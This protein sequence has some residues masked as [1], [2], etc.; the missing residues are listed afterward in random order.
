MSQG[1]QYLRLFLFLFGILINALYFTEAAVCGFLLLVIVLY[2][3]AKPKFPPNATASTE[4]LYFKT[5]FKK[6]LR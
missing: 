3:P 1:Q 2:F 5:G 6:F 4:R